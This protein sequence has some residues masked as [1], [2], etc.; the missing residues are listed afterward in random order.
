MTMR[1]LL[2]MLFLAL[3][4]LPS[5]A[6]TRPYTTVC[7]SCP[8]Y[9]R[10]VSFMVGSGYRQD[11]FN[12]RVA[13]PCEVPEALKK[14][15][16]KRLDI[17]TLDSQLDVVLCNSILLRA[18]GT[19]GKIYHGRVRNS[20]YAPGCPPE[21]APPF[22]C[23]CDDDQFEFKRTS[24]HVRGNVYDASLGLGYQYV[25]LN[26]DFMTTP[27]AGYAYDLQRFDTFDATRYINFD[28]NTGAQL[29][30]GHIHDWEG[31]YHTRWRSPWIGFNLQWNMDPCFTVYA[32]Y[33]YHWATYRAGGD[34]RRNRHHKH[35]D[36]HEHCHDCHDNDHD[37]SRGCDDHH[38]HDHHSHSHS[39]HDHHRHH[40]RHNGFSHHAR[41]KGQIIKAGGEWIM[42][43]GWFVGVRAEYQAWN[44]YK[45]REKTKV[46]EP[47]IDVFGNEVEL[48]LPV[49]LKLNRVNWRSMA[50]VGYIGF[51]W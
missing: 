36:H 39:S 18:D 22:N 10:D 30:L 16:W 3:L 34:W 13:G 15:N 25:W 51:E 17:W 47:V 12:W 45:G 20:K 41:G 50:Y 26:G 38:S 44:T 46:C 24:A 6:V 1:K 27:L 19:W 48:R 49:F 43:N 4:P 5:Q 2:M 31:H 37:H 33:Q 11:N 9:V 32:E 40:K 28:P 42:C 21:F 23:S 8:E 7:H 29:F 14:V 35:H